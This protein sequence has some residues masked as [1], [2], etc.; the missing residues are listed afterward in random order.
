MTC[1]RFLCTCTHKF[2]LHVLHVKRL[3]SVCNFHSA[4]NLLTRD[5]TKQW[6]TYNWLCVQW[7]WVHF[8]HMMDSWWSHWIKK[9]NLPLASCFFWKHLMI[10]CKI[11][12]AYL[13]VCAWPEVASDRWPHEGTSKQ[14]PLPGAYVEHILIK[15]PLRNPMIKEWRQLL[16]IGTKM[17]VLEWS[18]SEFHASSN[19][20][21]PSWTPVMD[22]QERYAACMVLSGVGDALGYK[23]G[24]WELVR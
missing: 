4:S 8:V 17:T 18:W 7:I 10:N 1:L 23:N 12:M 5:I 9:N 20:L 15:L 14:F 11:C 6:S 19:T 16:R 24:C 2:W 22:A 21:C 13:C 3:R